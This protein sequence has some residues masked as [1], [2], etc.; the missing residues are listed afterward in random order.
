MKFNK[1]N[2]FLPA[3]VDDITFSSSSFP[4]TNVVLLVI[5]VYY[6]DE[7]NMPPE[8]FVKLSFSHPRLL[9]MFILAWCTRSSA[10]SSG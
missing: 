5:D 8:P 10:Q 7:M 3:F 6:Y 2:L 4:C 9:L 1:E